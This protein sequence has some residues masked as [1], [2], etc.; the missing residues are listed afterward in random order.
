[1]KNKWFFA[2]LLFV[3]V[4]VGFAVLAPTNFDRLVLGSGNYGSDPNPTADITF[5]NDEYISNSTDGTI[6]F[7]AANLNSTGTSTFTTLGA[8]TVSGSVS[9]TD[10]TTSLI[11]KDSAGKKWK[12]RVNTQGVIRADSTGLN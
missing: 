1:M 11:L 8:T 6:S 2:I 4:T 9:A 12:L 10:S 7:G 3:F 5:Q